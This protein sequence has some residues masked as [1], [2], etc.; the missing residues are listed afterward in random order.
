M[1]TRFE[2]D[3]VAVDQEFAAL[4]P[5]LQI[6]ERQM[7]EKN[8]LA[9]GCRDPLVLWGDIIV[10]GH[11]RFEI[12]SRLGL[13]FQTVQMEFETRD[14]AT[15]WIIR[16]QFG[17][18]NLT[19]YQ[20]GILALRMKPIVEVRA[21]ANHLANAGDKSE[22]ACQNSDTPKI[23]KIRTNSVI[24]TLAGISHD[25]L[26]KVEKLD[27]TADPEVKEL[28]AKGEVSIN[29]ASKFAALP[30]EEQRQAL[31][32]ITE[33]QP[34]KEV[35]KQAVK[36]HV[37]NNS[38]NNEWYTPS[39]YIELARELMGGID[40]DPASSEIANQTV[41]ASQFFTESDNGL[42]QTWKG[43]VWMN[44]PYAQPLMS[45][46]AQAVTD[47]YETGEINQA[48]ILVNNATETRWFQTMMGSA[49]AVCFP[50]TRIKFLDPT[51]KPSGAPLQGQAIIYMGDDTQ[52]FID[53]FGGEGFIGVTNG[54]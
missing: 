43:N 9:D 7:L 45:D 53:A 37:A 52:A 11:N 19:D 10:D 1:N 8:I 27:A 34:A 40:T 29:L 13:G 28:A 31:E 42:A 39:K 49:S 21:K 51:G 20:R 38:G 3:R 16:N 46:F 47:K 25:T 35:V 22:A 44:P 5:P 50:A 23:E 4:I 14:D 54:L 32:S 18:R 36:A 24:S 2:L 26:R 33:E 6:E 48:C 41:K 12:C 17:R 15:L 30:V